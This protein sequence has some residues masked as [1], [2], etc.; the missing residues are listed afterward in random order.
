MRLEVDKLRVGLRRHLGHNLG[1]AITGRDGEIRR[2]GTITDVVPEPG[3]RL[4]EDKP[5]PGSVRGR[6]SCRGVVHAE[7]DI[8]PFR[9]EFRR[10]EHAEVLPAQSGIELAQ[11]VGALSLSAKF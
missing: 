2:R 9:Y 5:E 4:R 6:V 1:V 3:W 10:V 8:G 11:Q 7:D